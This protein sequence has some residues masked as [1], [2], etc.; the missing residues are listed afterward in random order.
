MRMRRYFIMMSVRVVCFVLMVVITPYGW[1]TWI[2]GIGAV[3]LPYLAVVV[4]NVGSDT[5]ET[6]ALSPERA[7]PAPPPPQ[8]AA[9]DA[10][11][12]VIRISEAGTASPPPAPPTPAPGTSG[13]PSG[14]RPESAAS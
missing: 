13:P 11:P 5:R 10:T 2:L 6:A 12:P 9:P 7:L 8:V 1:Q 14:A 4:A 3:F